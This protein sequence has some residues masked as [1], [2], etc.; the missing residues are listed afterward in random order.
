LFFSLSI[1]LKAQITESIWK[2]LFMVLRPKYT[3]H[4]V[5]L[6]FRIIDDQNEKK[7]GGS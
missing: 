4:K 5:N 1:R 2:S 6:L 7:I 3:P